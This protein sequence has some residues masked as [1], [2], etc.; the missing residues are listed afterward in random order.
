VAHNNLGIALA[1]QG[2][3]G[4]AIPEF[5]EAVRLMP[6]YAEAH[7]NLGVALASQGR[8]SEAIAHYSEAL[9]INPNYQEARRALDDLTS[10]GK[11]PKPGTP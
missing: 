11:R 2:K 6:D 3:A 8:F 10:R 4:D 5:L 9:R 7:N 1:R